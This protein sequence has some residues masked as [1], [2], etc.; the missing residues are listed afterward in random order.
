M[1][2]RG[3]LAAL[4]EELTNALDPLVLAIES[5]DAFEGFMRFLGW[6]TTGV[7]QPVQDLAG[8]AAGAKELVA[9]GNVD[10]SRVV[11][12]VGR[13][14]QAYTG[15]RGLSSI[16]AA[17]VGP[18]I[19]VAE[20]QA[21]F[22]GQLVDFLIVDH[23]EHR[24]PKIG[25][26][27]QLFGILR[28]RE[29]AKTATRPTYIR[30]EIDWH[31]FSQALK[32]P[33]GP[34]R[35]AYAFGTNDFDGTTFL[36]VVY[37]LSS[38]HGMDVRIGLLTPAERAFLTDG[39]AAAD[40]GPIHNSAI[41]WVIAENPFE[42]P[43]IRVGL[44]VAI[45]PATPGQLP[46]FAILPFAEGVASAAFL[47]T[48]QV[49][50]ELKAAFSLAGGVALRVRPNVGPSLDFG[51]G[52]GS[53]A[54]AVEVS[55]AIDVGNASGTKQVLIGDPDSSRLE[56]GKLGLRGGARVQSGSAPVAFVEIEA[57]DGSIVIAPGDDADGFLA[58]I[59]PK[60]MQVDFGGTLGVDAAN[61]LY[62]TG[63]A[64]LE[65]QLPVHITLGPIELKSATISIRPGSDGGGASIPIE[66]T[67]T[68]AADLGPLK[69][70]VEN[71]GVRA[72][73]TFPDG[74]GRI[75]PLDFALGFRAPNGVGLSVDAGVVR[76]GGFL[77]LDP[78]KG[79]Y[80]GALELALFDVINIQAIGLITT[81]MP[82][83]SR[84]F[85]LLIILT[86]EFGT[87]IQLGLGFTL[88][89]VGGLLGLNRAMR[90][91]VL[92]AGIRTGALNSVLFPHDVVANAPRIISD[93]RAIF[94]A[95]QG[96]FLIG[97]MVKLG[98][99][100]PTLVSLSLG[101]LIEIPGNVAIVGVLRVALPAEDAPLLVLQVS[102]LGAIEFDRK[103]VWFFA[104][105][106]DSRVLFVPIDGEMGLLA[107]FGDDSN[108]VVSV[109][110]FH[111]AFEPPP[112]PF[113]SPN[114]V[115]L[116][117][118]DTPV[119]RIS[120]MGYFAVTTNTAQFGAHVSLFYGFSF[121]KLEGELGFDALFRF[122]PFS[123]VIAVSASIG[124]KVFGVG[125]FSIHLD[126]TLEGPTPYRAHG[127]GGIDLWLVSF[128]A[129]FNITWGDDAP[130]TLP[131]LEVM[132]LLARELAKAESWTASIPD[133]NRL[134]VSLRP[135]DPLTE[136]A[137]L[138]PIGTLRVAQRAIPLD[139]VL[140]KVGNTAPT[141]GHRF[142]LKVRGGALVK[143][144]DAEEKFAP[145][146]FR[147]LEDADKLSQPAFQLEHAGLELVAPG[148]DAN[149]SRA[150]QRTVRYEEIIIDSNFKRAT[151]GFGHRGSLLFA[152]L[153]AGNAVARSSLS[154]ANKRARV[155]FTDKIAVASD[156]FTVALTRDNTAVSADATFSSAGAAADF[157]ASAVARDASL[158][159]QLQVIPAHEVNVA[160]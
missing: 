30:R 42:T 88:L 22:P 151:T 109:G 31:A 23:L 56:V 28:E 117:L 146:Q 112:L 32:D 34:F 95:Q 48:P 17:A 41:R 75:G 118:L 101:V 124:F 122:S 51:F 119:A 100:T 148:A 143:R 54:A 29:I 72:N 125:L 150:V 38:G 83:G 13:I 53:A 133:R 93:L 116:N 99:G 15:I 33:T 139:L 140:D 73:L 141:D 120:A 114:R 87:G 60:K 18:S 147:N 61:G 156:R 47:L 145:A 138:H 135:H 2:S 154:E 130:V 67:G 85:S 7:I 3:T 43:P 35:D 70:V 132:P 84:G 91:D 63:S 126:F 111:P 107:A 39:A 142:A 81:R 123:F 108:F 11:E 137:L 76:G 79:E 55:A 71:V 9:D 14:G 58:S 90:L 155:P 158:A 153:L 59:L 113:P 78:D 102:F 92:A 44:E 65:I 1:A 19:D 97:P 50:A 45:T 46:G 6:T 62:F 86:A 159:S 104:S 49:S 149:T 115:A 57:K 64:G 8:L 69:G 21:D 20:F 144:G 37:A 16:S 106:F 66:L 27:L 157:M 4:A 134:L 82:D 160:A 77:R 129:N 110:G 89:A 26:L 5:A 68:L 105:L 127:K 10:A 136:G 152:H 96:T 131:P 128:S 25:R 36:D 94:P 103:R 40:V 52:N 80:S 12:L 98:W 121:A 24:L 74:G